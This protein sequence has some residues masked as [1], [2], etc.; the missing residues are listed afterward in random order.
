MR[1]GAHLALLGLGLG[2]AIAAACA[3]SGQTGGAPG[4]SSGGGGGGNSSG[5]S[6]GGCG[7]TCGGGSGGGGN[8]SG[9]IIPPSTCNAQS[10]CSDFGT[11]MN[12]NCSNGQCVIMDGNVP[13]SAPS[14]FS[15]TPST[16]GGPCLVEPQDGTMFPNA[17][18]R[19]RISFAPASSSQNVFQIKVH[20]DSEQNDLIIYTQ[21]TYYAL[22]KALWLNLSKNLVGPTL[23]VTVTAGSMSGG[24]P[25]ASQTA[26]FTIA[27]VPASGALIYWSTASKD[28]NATT[29]QL[30]GFQVGDEGT[31]VAL[32]SSQVQQQVVAVPVDG[33]NLTK[34]KVNVFCI[35]CHTSTPDGNY[36]AF[37]AQWPWPNAIASVNAGDSGVPVGAPPPF[38]TAGGVDNLSPMLGPAS[39]NGVTF[40]QP[41]ILNQVMLGIQTF[42]PAHYSNGDHIVVS[43]LGADQ[44][45]TGLDAG[46]TYTG[47]DS[48]LA[49]FN[50]EW[51]GTASTTGTGLPAAP[52]G[53][54]PAPPSS[55]MATGASNGGWGIIARNGDSRSAGSP[56]WA[57][58]LDGNHDLIAYTS[59]DVGTKDGRMDQGTGD[60]YIVPYGS[61]GAGMGGAGGTAMPLAGA[62]DPNFNEYYP[63][64]AP[65]D[66]LIAFN[67]VAKGN[68][69]Y[70]QPAAEVYVVAP[71]TVGCD[72]TANSAQCRLKAN[73]PV[74]CTGSQSPGVQNTWP[75]WAPMPAV[76]TAGM[77]G[78]QGPDGKLYY[79]VT[80]S[81]TRANACTVTATSGQ[82]NTLCT[83][84]QSMDAL[85]HAQLYVAG[86]VVDPNNGGAITTYPAIYM[87]NQDA[88]LNNL[89]PAWDYF[90][91]AKGT[92]PPLQ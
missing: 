51:G 43:S 33:G 28:N 80:F 3:T 35:G 4:G 48:Q 91:I 52:C 29:T 46:N 27:S 10:P 83:K 53:T 57:H 6:S 88:A 7:L 87:W 84:Q 30:K 71:S 61:K 79:W 34:S 22:D 60:V 69:M 86:I 75:K 85:A 54:N 68:S 2:A 8:G 81:S 37:T 12:V 89:I 20:S 19:P 44:N 70:S 38:L 63:A 72:G 11:A 1:F 17:W 64:W 16:S 40:W 92:T 74:A 90:P 82:P 26:S 13:S 5:L 65:D 47:V 18:L 9:G 66:N 45:A 55:C 67:R 77:A 36:V 73:D 21:N 56:S 49:W 23:Q 78:N 41:P 15:G 59:T 58:N 31:T 76:A 50:L 32:T 14:V 24:T 25:A 42:S 39:A 62:S